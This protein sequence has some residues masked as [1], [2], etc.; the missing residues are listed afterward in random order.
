MG[1][2]RSSSLA[3]GGIREN[4]AFLGHEMRGP[5]GTER[6]GVLMAGGREGQGELGEGP[7]LAITTMFCSEFAYVFRLS[8][9]MRK[10]AGEHPFSVLIYMN[11]NIFHIC[12]IFI[13]FIATSNICFCMLD[14]IIGRNTWNCQIRAHIHTEYTHTRTKIK[15]RKKPKKTRGG[16]E[17]KKQEKDKGR[18]KKGVKEGE[19]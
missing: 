7:S 14:V 15:S 4:D 2:H 9:S 12:F 5:E 17:R 19:K 3:Q 6:V 8:V 18:K 1:C 10:V 11:S 16:Q 13:D